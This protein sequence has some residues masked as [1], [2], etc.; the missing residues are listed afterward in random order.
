MFFQH[1]RKIILGIVFTM[2]LGVL[3]FAGASPTE[4][5][6]G[7]DGYN[8]YT[9]EYKSK[10][11]VEVGKVSKIYKTEAE[12]KAY[13]KDTGRS[14]EA[15]A[16]GYYYD[17]TCKDS[18]KASKDIASRA[19]CLQYCGGASSYK[20]L[21]QK[22]YISIKAGATCGTNGAYSGAYKDVKDNTRCKSD[23]SCLPWV[24]EHDKKKVTYR[25]ISKPS[26]EATSSCP[27]VTKSKAAFNSSEVD[28]CKKGEDPKTDWEKRCKEEQ[29]EVKF[30]V[31]RKEAPAESDQGIFTKGLSDVCLGCGECSQC[32][33]FQVIINIVTFVF[34]MAGALAVFF[35]VNAGFSFALAKG[36]QEHITKAKGALSAAVIGV[37]IILIAWALV[38]TVL[39]YW[40]GYEKKKGWAYPTLE[41]RQTGSSSDTSSSTDSS[42]SK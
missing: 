3:M 14:A 20:S 10:T 41:C 25:C 42:S 15:V 8:C 38:N 26:S 29:T 31:C 9:Y 30:G 35:M 23:A 4:A 39:I 13:G 12:C 34:S 24:C 33:V 5:K 7:D 16:V 32:D 6:K 21:V 2:F 1:K 37:I 22:E 27:G 17:C 40:L 28:K 36:N 19:S 11:E 18:S